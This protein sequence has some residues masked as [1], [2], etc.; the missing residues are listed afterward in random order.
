MLAHLGEGDL[1]LAGR[2]HHAADL[3]ADPPEVKLPSE[4]LTGRAG[5]YIGVARAEKVRGLVGGL[6]P[7]LCAFRAFGAD[8]KEQID[9]QLPADL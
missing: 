5:R 9:Y 8:K 6:V 4:R 1:D 2:G 3:G 7:F